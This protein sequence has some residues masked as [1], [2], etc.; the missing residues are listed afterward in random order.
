MAHFDE[1]SINVIFGGDRH[2]DETCVTVVLKTEDHTLGNALKQVLNRYPEV[3]FSGYTITHPLEDKLLVRIQTKQGVPALKLFQR[4]LR[5]VDAI[6]GEIARKF[7][8]AM[9][10]YEEDTNM[11]TG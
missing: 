2:D 4:A 5:D 3:E 11:A 10:S 6:F 9:D 8:E 7:Q 1:E